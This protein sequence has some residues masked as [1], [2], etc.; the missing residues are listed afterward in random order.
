MKIT[1]KKKIAI[2]KTKKV[3]IEPYQFLDHT[4]DVKFRAY[5]KTLEETF[6]NCAMAVKETITKSE[7]SA[8]LTKGC[9]MMADDLEGL[10]QNFLEEI[11]FLFDSENFIVAKIEKLRIIK[12]TVGFSLACDFAGDLTSGKDTQGNSYDFEEHIKAIT[13]HEMSIKKVN[14]NYEIEVVLDV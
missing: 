5:G 9:G 6:E 7:I 10:L 2:K 4:A 11:I 13:Y 1:K 3:V 14:G 12:D 8:V